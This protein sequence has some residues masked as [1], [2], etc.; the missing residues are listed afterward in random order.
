MQEVI[1]RKKLDRNPADFPRQLYSCSSFVLCHC[2]T[3]RQVSRIS[4]SFVDS[5]RKLRGH[6]TD[7]GILAI[8]IPLIWTLK[9]PL[10]RKLLV[11]LLMCSGFFVI[12]SA[13]IR[14]ALTLQDIGHIDTGAIW[15]VRELFV[16]S[17]TVN[18]PAIKPLFNKTTWGYSEQARKPSDYSEGQDYEGMK[19]PNMEEESVCSKSNS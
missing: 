16:G 13:I 15:G 11:G 4:A 17:V 6:S 3:E 8:I 14:I 10:F 1:N 9:L 7:I 2:D 18:L 5:I 12:A 19:F